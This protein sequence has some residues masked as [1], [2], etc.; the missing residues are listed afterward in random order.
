MMDPPQA[1]LG[2]QLYR[3]S[4][5]H[6]GTGRKKVRHFG[7]KDIVP[8]CLGSEVS[9]V[10]SVRRPGESYKIHTFCRAAILPIV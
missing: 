5:R 4:Q 8:N 3:I 1:Y 7:T 2:L 6:F 10:R 9:R